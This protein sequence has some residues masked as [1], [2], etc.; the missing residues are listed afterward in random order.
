MYSFSESEEEP[1]LRP[2]G[3]DLVCLREGLSKCCRGGPLT[4]IIR[5]NS[6]IDDVLYGLENIKNIKN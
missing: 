5:H 3:L 2:S 1:K 6:L 4:S